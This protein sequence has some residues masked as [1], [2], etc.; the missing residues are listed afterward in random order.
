MDA[1]TRDG[2]LSAVPQPSRYDRW[3]KSLEQKSNATAVAFDIV[4]PSG[5]DIRAMRPSLLVMMRTGRIPDTLT[6]KVQHLINVAEDATENGGNGEAAVEAEMIRQQQENPA[7]FNVTWMQL[8]DA[9]WCESVVDPLFT[10]EPKAYPDLLPVADVDEQDK[11]FLFMWAQGVDQTVAEFLDGGK[12]ALAAVGN[13]PTSGEI[14]TG[15]SSTTRSQ[16]ANG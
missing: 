16:P 15:P 4:L 7:A 8:L 3:K 13:R 12:R 11:T 10:T 5:L 14:R 1:Y 9:V 2:G 6:Q